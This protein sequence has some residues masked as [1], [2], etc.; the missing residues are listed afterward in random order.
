MPAYSH[1]R[2]YDLTDTEVDLILYCLE[3]TSN[4]T[5]EEDNSRRRIVETLQEGNLVSANFDD[6]DTI[7]DMYSHYFET[8]H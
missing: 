8:D 1:K 2:S 5:T 4:L 3:S 7:D 6:Y